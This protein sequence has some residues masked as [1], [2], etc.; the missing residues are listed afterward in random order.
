MG[1]E[2]DGGM[3]VACMSTPVNRQVV[4]INACLK[5]AIILFQR[6]LLVLKFYQK[7]TSLSKSK[8]FKVEHA[9]LLL[10]FTD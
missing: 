10:I 9:N 1:R 5:N 4:N 8:I 3:D 6:L 7:Y 2:E